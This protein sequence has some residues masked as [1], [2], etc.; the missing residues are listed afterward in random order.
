[1]PSVAWAL[2]GP[3]GAKVRAKLRQR[4]RARE[5][6]GPAV[7][8]LQVLHACKGDLAPGT[9]SLLLAAPGHGKSSLL[10]AVAGHLPAEVLEG[11]V[12][13]NG[14]DA[15]GLRGQGVHLSLVA[16][17]VEQTDVHMAF[18][19]VLE[20][21]AF[22]SALSTVDPAL[23]GHPLLVT[24][25]R[26]RVD[27]VLKLLHLESCRNTLL[28]NEIVRGVS[29]GERKRVT[30]AEVLVGAA[31]VLCLDE[32]STGL[33][34]SVTYDICASI[35]AWC[36]HMR[37]TVVTALQQPTPEVYSLFDNIILLREVR[38]PCTPC[39]YTRAT[40]GVTDPFRQG[41]TVFHGPRDL[42]PLHLQGMGYP[43]PQQGVTDI[44]DYLLEFLNSPAQVLAA[45]P[46]G[47]AGTAP[48]TTKGLVEAWT[49]RRQADAK[50][51]GEAPAAE[52]IVLVS[53]FAKRQYGRP[54]PRSGLSAF[55]TLLGR[56]STLFWRN[57]FVVFTRV[58][59]TVINSMIL[60]LVWLQLTLSQGE[61]KL[62]LFVFSLAQITFASFPVIT[63]V[64]ESKAV[65][66][67]HIKAGLYPSW[68]FTLSTALADLPV[69]AL[70]TILYT[71]ILY[72]STGL[73]REAGRF[74]F[75]YLITFCVDFA[76]GSLF[77]NIAYVMPSTEAA[78]AAS[79]PFIALQ[80]VF[81]G[82]LIAPKD[83][84][85]HSWL[86]WIYYTSVFAYGARS[87]SHNE[88][89]A[90][91]Y[92]I[93]PALNQT[94]A[95]LV[96]ATSS[97]SG[98][99]TLITE[100]G[101]PIGAW[102]FPPSTC[103]AVPGLQCGPTPYGKL[104]MQAV[105]INLE[106]GWKWGGVG[107]L[108][109]FAVIQILLAART[110]HKATKSLSSYRASG[111]KSYRPPA[112]GEE[113]DDTA[114]LHVAIPDALEA[115]VTALPF[116]PCSLAWR[117]LSY[118]V[119]TPQG[120][121]TL[122]HGVSGLAVPRRLLALMGASGAG[123][124]TLLDVIACRKTQGSIQGDILVDGHALHKAA[125]ARC[126][127]Y[128]EQLDVHEPLATVGEAIHFSA[129]LRLPA[130]VTKEQR[131]AFVEQTMELLELN[132][133]S[134]RLVGDSDSGLSPSQR[135][136]LT[137]AVELV[138]N[139]PILFLDEP[140]SGLDARAALMVMK[141]CQRISA[142]RRTV[143]ATVHQP[144]SEIFSLFDDLLLMQRGGYMA[145]VG[146]LCDGGAALIRH[147][148][149]VPGVH[150]CPPDMNPASWML[151]VLAGADSSSAGRRKSVELQRK[152]TL[153]VLTDL[154][155]P[156]AGA[157]K[158]PS[159]ADAAQAPGVGMP[160]GNLAGPSLMAHL[161]QSAHW[162]ALEGALTAAV[163]APAGRVHTAAE[164]AAQQGFAQGF[165]TQVVVVTTR[166]MR[167]YSR[168]LT[169]VYTRIKVLTILNLLFAAV[170]Y[171]A[172]QA[173]DCAAPQDLDKSKC[174][175]TPLGVQNAL[176]IVFINSLCVSRG[177]RLV[178]HRC[179]ADAPPL[180][181]FLP[182]VSVTSLMPYLFRKRVIMYR[183]RASRMYRPEAYVISLVVTEACTLLLTAFIVL[184]P[185]YFCVGFLDKPSDYFT[186]IFII[187]LCM[188][189]FMGIG[190]FYAAHFAS[191]L[192]AQAVLSLLLPMCALF[193]GMYLP[194]PQI[195]NGA[196]NGHPHV[197]WQW[198]YYLDPVSHSLEALSAARFADPG[199]SST[200]NHMINVT[201]G[202]GFVQ[203]DA[204]QYV[205]ATRGSQYSYRWRQVGYLCIIAFGW[206]TFHLYAQRTKIHVTR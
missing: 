143:V 103:A 97:N 104:I 202:A 37:G 186:Y 120:P 117:D 89:L 190:M 132:P 180:S 189:C 173:V 87:L 57:K 164:E 78:S 176:G 39:A 114:P 28:G 119:D 109:G 198:A 139:A 55:R 167:N 145:F 112:A 195:P 102:F 159:P 95:R 106:P 111:N 156:V 48:R 88:F 154:V 184:T 10:R 45:Q 175:N 36:T 19:T 32:I 92:N 3:L 9:M 49:V 14:V 124:T 27:A 38:L 84:G 69:S 47:D 182:V 131:A 72:F 41:A 94:T 170:W 58:F 70:Q 169:F 16:Q 17:Y 148:S 206:Q 157:D 12:L 56:A 74:F 105:N 137:I 79:A 62:A 7:K 141:V 22:A 116:E 77:R 21:V 178:F 115:A 20:T 194:K 110:V 26:N 185:V 196:A 146:P 161:K 33:D 183:E 118:T 200:V 126:T 59:A 203:V 76:V 5:G 18:L 4:Q 108:L 199:R 134:G 101:A 40:G 64:S 93:F 158:S 197:Y 54:Y 80:L 165:L 133:I 44:A 160:T 193:G 15:A 29:G 90:P 98:G 172:Q 24:A 181:R 53:D 162:S 192:T 125:F 153:T 91:E 140:T 61:A 150:P 166:S 34:A 107:F 6:G 50:A 149:A 71:L 35:R 65:G 191:P 73:S 82:F 201:A 142:T 31:R 163:E 75:F 177:A 127:A 171:K 135:K 13:Y 144:S 99:G 11:T 179:I 130:T 8:T 23:M 51:G 2:T 67:K 155:E 1:M 187:W 123:K 152:S 85:T 129:A 43:L 100:A 83:M 42:L 122:L 66:Y 25:A 138:S 136:V 204:M 128:C 68:A 63:A 188:L 52:G 147:L 46:G 86:I 81:A 30:V 96:A 151:D 205:E 168:S 60:G 113:G 121:K 174:N